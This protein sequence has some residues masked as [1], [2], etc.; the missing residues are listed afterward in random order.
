MKKCSACGELNS[1]ETSS[2]KSCAAPLPVSS[3]SLPKSTMTKRDLFIV[4]LRLIGVYLIVF[5][6]L[7]ALHKL[8]SNYAMLRVISQAAGFDGF[9]GLAES[10]QYLSIFTGVIWDLV[11]IV[12]G[13]YFC[14]GG[15]LL[16][17]FV[18][19]KDGVL[20]EY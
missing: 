10:M 19:M 15:E 2:C 11:R 13:L 14:R 8:G 18:R 16:F 17:N 1:D 7:G 20:S 4:G 5:G 3:T 12:V 6:F 9:G